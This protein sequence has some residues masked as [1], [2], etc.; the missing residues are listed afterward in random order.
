MPP[1]RWAA[2]SALLSAHRGCPPLYTERRG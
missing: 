1:E 2:V